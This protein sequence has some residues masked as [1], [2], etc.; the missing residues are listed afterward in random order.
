MR[1]VILNDE[2]T[3]VADFGEFSPQEAQE[4]FTDAL[5]ALEYRKNLSEII[6][7]NEVQ[8]HLLTDTLARMGLLHGHSELIQQ[9]MRPYV[10]QEIQRFQ[11]RRNLMQRTADKLDTYR[12]KGRDW[13]KSQLLAGF[14]RLFS[15]LL[16]RLS[17]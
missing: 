6:V 13:I 12:Q 11:E 9:W 7:R 17:R 4:F 14:S 8:M 1:L 15:K 3:V 16:K 2:M 10:A 5:A